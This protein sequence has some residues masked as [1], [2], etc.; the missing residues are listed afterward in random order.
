MST[1]YA[2]QYYRF[3]MGGVSA[4]GGRLPPSPYLGKTPVEHT[5]CDCSMSGLTFFPILVWP[6]GRSM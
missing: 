5:V 1:D 2:V 3:E 4:E 6:A